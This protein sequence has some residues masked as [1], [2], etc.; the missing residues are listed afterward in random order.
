MIGRGA[1]AAGRIGALAVA[2][3]L[4]ACAPAEEPTDERAAA[5]I[6]ML[7]VSLGEALAVMEESELVAETLGEHLFDYFL[8]NKRREW[9]TYK[10]HVTEFELDRYLPLL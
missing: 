7:P 6:T 2:A 4:A 1:F 10:T 9:T 3:A 8:A 5:G